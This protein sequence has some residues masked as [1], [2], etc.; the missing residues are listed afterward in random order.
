L[1]P[2]ARAQE[3]THPVATTQPAATTLPAAAP[4]SQASLPDQDSLISPDDVLDVYVVDAPEFSR[5]YR[6]SPDGAILVPLLDAPIT[7]AGLKVT[8]FARLLALQLQAHELV[9]SPHVV[10]SIASSRV[11][12]V[13]V[14]GAVKHPQLYPVFARTTLLDVLSQ[15]EGLAPEAGTIAVVTRGEAGL[16]AKPGER[17]VTVNLSSLLEKGDLAAN[18]VIYPGDRVMVPRSGVVYV[19]GAVNKPGGIPLTSMGSGM[20]VMQAIAMASDL[21][22]T[23]VR[24]KSMIVRVDPAASGGRAQVPLDLKKI[25]AGKAPDPQ[26]QAD[27]ILFVPDSTSA[28]ALRRGGEAVLQTAVILAGYGRY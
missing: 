15:A 6:V 22:P 12:S 8:E 3:A 2:G 10:V 7:A 23:A 1:A 24:S 13:A 17:T 21:K 18:I 9:S 27:D 28:K 26:L 25:L 5:Q 19:V 11:K 20:T 4:I 16:T 14:T